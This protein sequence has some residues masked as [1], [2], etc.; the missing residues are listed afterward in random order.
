ME[1]W[2]REGDG[3]V[4]KMEEDWCDSE[5]VIETRAGG[6]REAAETDGGFGF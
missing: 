2:K 5:V 6:E 4:G 1:T 3:D